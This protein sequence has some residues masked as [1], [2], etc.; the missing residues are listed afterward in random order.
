LVLGW[1][2]VLVSE[3]TEKEEIKRSFVS[4]SE[5][6]QKAVNLHKPPP[7]FDVITD[8]CLDWNFELLSRNQLLEFIR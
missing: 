1:L 4:H 6:H 3:W 2:L 8:A 7:S 5:S